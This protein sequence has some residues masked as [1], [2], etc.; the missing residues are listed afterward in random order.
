MVNFYRLRGYQ[1]VNAAN[2]LPQ[3]GNFFPARG[4]FFRAFPAASYT[5]AR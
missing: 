2:D 4:K 1:M 5:R 3:T